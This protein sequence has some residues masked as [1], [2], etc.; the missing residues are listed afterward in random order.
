MPIL[1]TFMLTIFLFSP[2]VMASENGQLSENSLHFMSFIFSKFM[3]E[4]NKKSI[5]ERI[6]VPMR[7]WPEPHIKTL[8]L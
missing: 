7:G 4:N 8:H 5:L 2:Y 1:K 6:F 3:S